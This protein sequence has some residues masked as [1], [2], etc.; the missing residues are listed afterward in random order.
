MR[1]KVELRHLRYFTTVAD[2]CHFGRAAKLL[3]MTQS[4]L[5]LAI[6]QLEDELGVSLLT[7]TTR[8]VRLTPA[9]EFFLT[10]AQ[11]ILRGVDLGIRSV[12]LIG[13]GRLGLVRIGFTGMSALL[14][15][16]TI[17]QAVKRRLPKAKVEIHDDLASSS[18]CD[19][20]RDDTMDIGMLHPPFAGDGLETKVIASE[21]LIVVMRADHRLAGRPVVLMSDLRDEDF[22]SYREA[23]PAVDQ[24]VARGCSDAGFTPRDGHRASST[25]A[26]LALVA[27]GLGVGVVPASARALPIPGIAFRDLTGVPPVQLALAWRKAQ[28]APMMSAVLAVLDEICPGPRPPAAGYGRPAGPAGARPAARSTAARAR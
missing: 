9:G 15:L 19:R 22:V 8:Q 4:T 26:L 13:D 3:H 21:P 28:T 25:A 16:S 27:G 7:R 14:Y 2:T 10:E 5:S 24:A 6:R 17:I 1:T 23:D 20:L 11:R 18:Q 12:R